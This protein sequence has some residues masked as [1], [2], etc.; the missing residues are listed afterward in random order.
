MSKSFVIDVDVVK[1]YEV[2]R[3]F[4]LKLGYDEQRAVR[5]KLLVLKRRG[6]IYGSTSSNG[7]DFLIRLRAS[8]NPVGDLQLYAT[9]LLTIRCDYDVKVSGGDGSSSD[10][11]ALE[12]EVEQLRSQFSGKV[13]SEP[14][15]ASEKPSPIK[16]Q[17]E[18][19]PVHIPGRI[20]TGYEDLDNLLLGGLPENYAV[21]ITSPSS[22][23]RKILVHKF[24][25]AGVEVGQIT[26]YIAL[27]PGIGRTLAEEFKS[28]FYLFVCNPRVDMKI[29]SL[30]NVFKLNGVGTL[31]DINIALTKS[32]RMLDASRSGPRRACIEIISDVLLQHHAVVTRKWL[33]SLLSDLKSNGFTSLAI[34]NPLMHSQEDVQ[35]ILG[36]FDGEIRISEKET[37]KGI[38]NILRIRKMYNQQYLKSELIISRER[39]GS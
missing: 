20:S 4:F 16:V 38:E 7:K 15:S 9:N 30:A 29:E 10:R 39:L 8:F 25:K 18:N 11:A 14:A 24:L 31:S 2:A 28:S 35:A 33:S 27:D 26:F 3:D 1:A 21:V 13:F 22:D 17:Q 19:I 32:L 6:N 37:K 5:P 34:V 12:N 36:L 23:E